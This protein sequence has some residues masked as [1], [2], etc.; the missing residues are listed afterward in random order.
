MVPW[1]RLHRVVGA[2]ATIAVLLSSVLLVVGLPLVAGPTAAVAAPRRA[3]ARAGQ[4]LRGAE[5]DE[6]TVLVRFAPGLDRAGRDAVLRRHG[7]GRALGREELFG[8]TAVDTHGHDPR[9]LRSALAAVP[10]VADVELDLIRRSFVEAND[11]YYP[12]QK[13]YLDEVRV[14]L[15]WNVT[16]TPIGNVVIAVVDSGID[17]T[18]PDL[19][20]R[21]VP[22]AGVDLVD[23]TWPPQDEAGH[24]TMVAGV[25]DAATDNGIGVAGVART[26]ARVLPVRV[27]DANGA[28]DD[29]R[30]AE[31]ITYAADHGAQI[32]NLSLGG[33]GSTFVLQSAVQYAVGKGALVVAAS[34][35][36]SPYT[37]FKADVFPA[38]YP[39]VLA[40]GA[41]DHAGHIV[42]YSLHGRYVD[43]A[44]PGDHVLTTAV[45]GSYAWADG[46]S[47]AS[48]LVAGAAAIVWALHT[49]WTAAQVADRLQATAHDAG[50]P[51]RDDV[52]GSGIL[53]AGAAV[54]Q[55]AVQPA[56]TTPGADGF[57]P[58]NLA[59]SATP[60]MAGPTYSATIAPEGE[61]DWYQISVPASATV[62]VQV[63][64]P[65]DGDVTTGVDPILRVRQ[66][67][68]PVVDVD[69]FSSGDPETASFFSSGGGTYRIEVEN[70]LPTIGTGPYTL[71]VVVDAAASSPAP[72][73]AP[74]APTAKSGYWMVGRDGAVYGFGDAA[75]LG[76]V[77]G[78]RS[79]MEAVDLEPTPSLNGYWAVTNTGHVY[80]FG[81]APYLGGV[82]GA[83]AFG[84]AV[85]S[86]SATPSGRGY[87]LFTTKGRVIAFGDAPFLGDMSAQR[88]N[89]PVLDSIPTPTGAGY[90][91]V[92]S[93]GGI[94]TFGDAAFRGSMGDAKLNAPV[95]S[96]VPDRDGVGYWLVASDGGIFSFEAP[97]R[98]SMGAVK[99]NGP[100]TGMVRFGDGYLM[101]GTDGGIFNFS[102][103]AFFGSLGANPPAAPIVSVAVAER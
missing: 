34:G 70:F 9:A 1:R 92:A 54:G 20:T 33:Y 68:V 64:P 59:V 89:G 32:I 88:L 69:D 42:Y 23:H 8:V 79:G 62:T 27:L 103:K 65:R 10:G 63:L 24:G 66:G 81:D 80:G 7:V 13:P 6:H 91:M 5:V 28:T 84:E 99:L 58:N 90:Y 49:D 50:L 74:V 39:G 55:A 47:F 46:T 43:L 48:P 75:H 57:E 35:N 100:I 4:D 12:Q 26:V 30:L 41:T 56:R 53:D 2:P 60:I 37:V 98:G 15:A 96:L 14:P 77:T 22:D 71:R 101:V 16:T 25:A 31:G 76:N 19:V 73:P 102:D 86:I 29:A 18:H 51:G 45:A 82:N 78:L 67:D 38:A 83:V 40:V 17:L 44:A 36:L 61:V 52:Y 21:V 11:P 72:A 85:T 87:W 97:F 3:A 93:D 94:F 95:Q